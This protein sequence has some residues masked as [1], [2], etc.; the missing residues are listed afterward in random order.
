MFLGFYEASKISTTLN[1]WT[2]FSNRYSTL[3]TD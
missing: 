2:P 1:E 3:Q